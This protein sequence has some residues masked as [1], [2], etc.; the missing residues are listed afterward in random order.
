[1]RNQFIKVFE[2]VFFLVFLSLFS[3]YSFNLDVESDGV[4][5]KRMA[6]KEQLL[7]LQLDGQA[8]WTGI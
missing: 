4:Q 6:F 2:G 3:A 1:L 5:A 7:G 8:K